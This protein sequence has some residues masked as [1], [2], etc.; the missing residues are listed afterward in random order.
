[1]GIS[2]LQTNQI[3]STMKFLLLLAV[4]VLNGA[5]GSPA[6]DQVRASPM[7]EEEALKYVLKDIV[8]CEAEGHTWEEVFA[9]LDGNNDGCYTWE[10][11]WDFLKQV[12]QD[13]VCIKPH[14]DRSS[15]DMA[16]VLV[17]WQCM[18]EQLTMGEMTGL[19]LHQIF[20]W[21]MDKD[22]DGC[23]NIAEHKE[24]AKDTKNNCKL[25]KIV[26]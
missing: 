3:T 24:W 25:A 7:T 5:H 14:N 10:E 11:S 17:W 15:E 1:M 6:N 18:E 13:H 9:T 21:M 23:V 12:N 22:Q 20:D 2:L 16:S 26:E 19:S 4:I 8:Q